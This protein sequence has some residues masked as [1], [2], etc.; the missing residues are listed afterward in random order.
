MIENYFGEDGSG[1]LL[2]WS[3]EVPAYEQSNGSVK[4]EMHS[5]FQISFVLSHKDTGVFLSHSFSRNLQEELK[6]KD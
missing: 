6:Q 1:A 4:K 3:F 2:L 5:T